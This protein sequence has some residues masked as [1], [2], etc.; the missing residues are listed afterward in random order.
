M[1]TIALLLVGVAIGWTASSVDWTRTAVGQDGAIGVE[2]AIEAEAIAPADAATQPAN[3]PAGGGERSIRRQRDGILRRRGLLPARETPPAA[4]A[5]SE[6]P[7]FAPASEAPA[8]TEAMPYGS[9]GAELVPP[10]ADRE[11]MRGPALLPAS[12]A[13]SAGRYQLAAYNTSSQYGYYI[14]DTTTG[15]VW[16]GVQGSAPRL[17]AETL[18]ER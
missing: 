11:A 13:S 7:A 17:V 15:R 1:R 8:S 10:L 18:P 4:N 3:D 9:P 16:H 6:A 5:P 12:A 2:P 14:V